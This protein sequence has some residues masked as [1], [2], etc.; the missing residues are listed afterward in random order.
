[1]FT[2]NSNCVFCN[3]T[4]YWMFPIVYVSYLD[5]Q[6]A[7]K[8]TDNISVYH[9]SNFNTKSM[10]LEYEFWFRTNFCQKNN[11]SK[12]Y[13][14]KLFTFVKSIDFS[15]KT[16]SPIIWVLWHRL[17][18]KRACERCQTFITAR[19]RQ[20]REGN[21]IFWLLVLTWIFRSSFEVL[22]GK[23]NLCLPLHLNHDF[24]TM[25]IPLRCTA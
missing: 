21:K 19:K 4:E 6:N 9:I 14:C 10:E 5:Y 20:L 11:H 12:L 7:N 15:N 22:F 3:E 8:R 23:S 24:L 18:T 16:M 25:N 13:F 2:F 1:M 17:L